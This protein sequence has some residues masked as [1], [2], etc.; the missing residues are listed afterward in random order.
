M[1]GSGKTTLSAV[2]VEHVLGRYADE[3]TIAVVYFFFDYSDNSK[4]RL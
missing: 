2:V 4:K 1:P 3:P